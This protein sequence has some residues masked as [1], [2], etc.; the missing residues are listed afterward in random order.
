MF[1]RVSQPQLATR[2][3]VPWILA[4]T[5]LCTHALLAQNEPAS[6]A[7]SPPASDSARLIELNRGIRAFIVR[8]LEGAKASF[9]RVLGQEPDNAACLYYLGLI[10]LEEGLRLSGSDSQAAQKKFD[11]ARDNLEHVTRSA[12]PTVIPV[13]AGLLLGI[14][15]LAADPMQ[16]ADTILKLAQSAHDT[17][18]RYVD[19]VD[20]GKNDRYALFYLGVACYRLGDTYAKPPLNNPS[21]SKPYFDEAVHA[22]DA[23]LKCAEIDRQSEIA[24]PGAPR[25]LDNQEYE[26]FKLRHTYYQGLVALQR[27]NNRQARESLGFVRDNEKGKIG[28]NAAEILQKLDEIEATAPS[29]MTFESPL[30]R[31]DVQG[32]V[33]FGMNYDT[34]VIL[35]GRDTALPLNIGR[36]HDFRFETEAN[37][38]I[39][40]YIDKTEAPVGESLSI[41]IGGG[42]AHGWYT[43]IHPFNLNQYSGRAFVQWQPVKDCYLG[44]EYEYSYTNLGA[45]PFISSHRITPVMSHIWRAKDSNDELG[46]TD[47]WYNF[48]NR[49]YLEEISDRRLNRDG[50]YHAYGIRHIFNLRKAADLWA[51][52]YAERERERVLFG[53]RWLNFSLGYVYRDERTN[54]TEFDLGGHSI[55]SGIG[56]P[57]P[58]RLMFDIEGIFTWEDYSAPSVFDYRRNQRSDFVQ[59][60]N[61]GLTRTFVARGEYAAIPTLEIKL[62]AGIGWTLRNSNIWDRL[63]QDVYE[64]DR[65]VYGL[66][67]NFDF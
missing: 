49:D 65:T 33:S 36:Q 17:L 45:A 29:P 10:Y 35:L 21:R 34:N 6:P 7:Q 20:G 56:V 1:T 58:W 15:Q 62:R 53:E 57:L 5:F 31:L 19:E 61:F 9:D 60:Y 30:G 25:G 50:N 22:F 63:S 55:L 3:L 11:Q 38:N 46:R 27:R 16:E 59:Q 67:L 13:E 43:D 8:D 54:G 37:F 39:T 32:N 18:K 24:A 48:D 44:V 41:G 12:D 40:R 23:A 52:Y 66:T 4:L 14:A 64:Y 42:T 26:Q 51:S 2:L 47:I 28:Q